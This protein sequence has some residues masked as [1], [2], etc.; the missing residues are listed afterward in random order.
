MLGFSV[1]LHSGFS[2]LNV[3][4][5]NLFHCITQIHIWGRK[6]E[7]FTAVFGHFQIYFPQPMNG[8][9]LHFI[10]LIDDTNKMSRVFKERAIFEKSLL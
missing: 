7:K 8:S 2:S 10:C 1:S 4:F 9:L 6:Q 3:K 5:L